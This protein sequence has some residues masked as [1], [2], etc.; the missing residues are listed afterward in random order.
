MTNEILEKRHLHHYGG[1]SQNYLYDWARRT[2]HVDDF[3]EYVVDVEH[4][5][6]TGITWGVIRK[7]AESADPEVPEA[8]VKKKGKK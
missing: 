6:Q 8:P 1:H 7:K 4:D 2:G 3:G 5:S